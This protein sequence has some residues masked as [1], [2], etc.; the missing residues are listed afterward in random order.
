MGAAMTGKNDIDLRVWGKSRGLPTRYALIWHL[1]D[2]AAVAAGLWDEYLTPNQ[3]TVIAAG[4]ALHEDDART[5]VAFLA[6]LHDLGKCTA[7]FQHQD[8]PAFQVLL[9]A[10][11]EDPRS[12]RRLGHAAA[13][14]LLA[15]PLLRDA[16]YG[17][18][19]RP[20][21]TPA[22]VA[23]QVLGGHHGRFQQE[24]SLDYMRDPLRRVPQLTGE[25]W[26]RQR[27]LIFDALRELLGDLPVPADAQAPALALVTGVIIL[28]DWLVSQESFLKERL[29]QLSTDAGPAAVAAHFAAS[30]SAV[31][32][33]LAEAG[34]G[35]SVLPSKSFGDIFPF[36]ANPLQRSLAHELV[37]PGLPGSGLLVVAAAPGEGKTEAALYAAQALAVAA[38]VEGCFFAL[39]TMATADQMYG[40]V[41]DFLTRQAPDTTSL[42]LLH[43]MSWLNP[44]YVN[45][46]P[47]TDGSEVLSDEQDAGRPARIVAT[48]WLRTGK[49]GLLASWS[50]GT[51]DQGLLAM[52]PVPHNTLRLLGISRKVLVVDEAHAYDPY[53]QFLLRRLVAWCGRLGCPVVL[54]SATLPSSVSRSLA[55]AYRQ[56]AGHRD[57]LPGGLQVPY[58]GWLFVPADGSAP[59]VPS[60]AARAEMAASRPVELPVKVVPVRHEGP[61]GGG[62]AEGGRLGAV[63][64][65]LSVI[66][67]GGGCAAVICNTVA[68]AQVTF[69]HLQAWARSQEAQPAVY[70][71]HSRFPAWQR[72]QITETVTELFGKAAG[73]R[74]PAAAIVV[75]TQVIE[76]SLDLD[77]DLVVSDLAPMALLLQR[78]GRCHRHAIEGRPAGVSQPLLVVLD[79]TDAQGRHARPRH[80]GE[81][82]GRY[83]LRTTRDLLLARGTTPVRVPGDVQELVEQVYCP[84]T[85]DGLSFL[86]DDERRLDEWY[87]HEGQR[88]AQQGQAEIRAIKEP[89]MLSDLRTLSHNDLVDDRPPTRL[90]AE[91]CRLVPCY[92]RDGRSLWLDPAARTTPLPQKPAG[93]R[94][95]P[96]ELALI[97]QHTVPVRQDEVRQASATHQPPPAWRDHFLLGELLLLP[98]RP[99]ADDVLPQPT[100]DLPFRLHPRLGLQK[101]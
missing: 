5:V 90:G 32:R 40:R 99:A 15:Y 10:G 78:A 96:D 4:L 97:M 93:Q 77:F 68:D 91:S 83:L 11:F 80:W 79:P 94:F 82:Y 71:L 84:D 9:D 61:A 101:L 2:A 6:G 49:R 1:V 59:V 27:E 57:P 26:Q 95:S 8:A 55:E 66:G 100:G 65:A 54:L 58:P 28:A 7:D 3:R 14:Q 63:Q 50:T 89:A 72:Q 51:V 42:T 31:P 76:Q 34:L 75:A 38:G 21:R 69:A 92:V 20:S 33:L 45:V 98:H 17:A 19:G 70:L 39:P 67:A 37:A 12:E 85:G 62:T 64:E 25:A 29:G 13:S 87:E 36:E 16:G 52:L 30:R 48:R 88:L 44:A 43:S 60:D 18:G 46:R 56:G 81:V 41:R 73:T 74:R 53:M 23:A 47:E 35:R 24:L 86:S 22:Y